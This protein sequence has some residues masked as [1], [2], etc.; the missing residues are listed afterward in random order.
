VRNLT[1]HGSDVTDDP[2]RADDVS[3]P[4][5]LSL[6]D[7]QRIAFAAV[8]L[9]SVFVIDACESHQAA[10]SSATIA[11]RSVPTM[12]MRRVA[13]T[14]PSNIAPATD[15]VE[16]GATAVKSLNSTRRFYGQCGTSA[17]ARPGRN[18]FH[19]VAADYVFD[20]CF[21]IR[22]AYL[23]CPIDVFS[24]KAVA[25]LAQNQ[26]PPTPHRQATTAVWAMLLATGAH[27]HLQTVMPNRVY[28][29]S[30]NGDRSLCRVP[31]VRDAPSVYFARCARPIPDGTID[32][33]RRLVKVA[34]W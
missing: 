15:V 1:A 33:V 31:E 13:R 16:Y 8:A 3:M 4:R 26:L 7:L 23:T 14:L 25:F 18:A 22:N 21:V 34:Y 5:C 2:Q 10:K 11:S 32:E 24:G 29:M 27:C 12:E 6:A 20:P 19:C 9:S 17:V 30:C 28:P